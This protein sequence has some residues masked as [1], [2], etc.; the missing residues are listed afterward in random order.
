M[1]TNVGGKN[2]LCTILSHSYNL[3]RSSKDNK[4]WRK[5]KEFLS[6]PKL[7][8]FSSVWAEILHEW[9][10]RPGDFE[11]GVRSAWFFSV[12]FPLYVFSGIFPPHLHWTDQLISHTHIMKLWFLESSNTT[13][14]DPGFAQPSPKAPQ[15]SR[16]EGRRCSRRRYCFWALA[17][18]IIN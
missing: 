12:F 3:I 5:N 10:S 13:I 4:K 7:P 9:V 14:N 6:W 2:Y 16:E 8:L 15:P 11:F 17:L 18:I 1:T